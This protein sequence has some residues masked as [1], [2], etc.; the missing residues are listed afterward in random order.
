MNDKALKY[1]FRPIGIYCFYHVIIADI[2]IS[3]DSKQI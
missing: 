1:C 2:I 3:A